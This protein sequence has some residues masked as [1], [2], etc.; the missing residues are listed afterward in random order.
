MKE[1]GLC[2]NGVLCQDV[3]MG[4][5]FSICFS[6][7]LMYAGTHTCIWSERS[8][9]SL[10]CAGPG[11][12]SRNSWHCRRCTSHLL[13][14][15]RICFLPS[16]N[17]GGVIAENVKNIEN[18]SPGHGNDDMLLCSAAVLPFSKWHT[19]TLCVCSERAR[20]SPVQWINLLY[21]LR[22][23]CLD[24][25]MVWWLSIFLQPCAYNC[26]R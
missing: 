4:S 24:W 6:W 13:S 1:R 11:L 23:P 15:Y 14:V 17:R 8:K 16:L 26:M 10:G 22:S 2:L 18:S 9:Q 20:V 12:S 7:F 19:R 25:H 21:G 5:S 3:A